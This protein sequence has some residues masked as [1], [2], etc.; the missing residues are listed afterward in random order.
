MAEH[1]TRVAQFEVRRRQNCSGRHAGIDCLLSIAVPVLQYSI[2][3]TVQHNMNYVHLYFLS[4]RQTASKRPNLDKD[5]CNVTQNRLLTRFYC[6]FITLTHQTFAM[7]TYCSSTVPP[8][9][10]AHSCQIPLRICNCYQ[11][12]HR[13][14]PNLYVTT[15][16]S[17]ARTKTY[18]MKERE[19]S[20]YLL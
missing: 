6:I 9:T 3:P 19:G 11:L 8:S 17:E 5:D 13:I 1:C 16:I 14:L 15:T 20:I 18:I 12:G 4:I 7:L 2:D 10:A